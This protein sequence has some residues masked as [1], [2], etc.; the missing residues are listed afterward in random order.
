MHYYDEQLRDLQEQVSKKKKLEGTLKALYPQKEELDKKVA[1]L[2][3]IKLRE[4][5]DV[6]KLENGSLSVFFYNVIGKKEEK[7][8]KERQEAYAA[9]AKYNSAIRELEYVNDSIRSSEEELNRLKGSEAKYQ[10]LLMEKKESIKASG[11][12]GAREILDLEEQIAAVHNLKKELAEA[13]KEGRE[14][15][16]KVEEVLHALDDADSLG[17]WDAWGGDGIF[18]HMAKHDALDK[19][20]NAVEALQVELRSFKTELADVQMDEDLKVNLDDFTRFADW[21]FDNI[22]T[23]LD[24]LDQIHESQRKMKHIDDKIRAILKELSTKAL[25]ADL[26]IKELQE[27]LEKTIIQT[28]I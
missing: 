24:V 10:S 5:K 13:E 21:F 9:A 26:E 19:A 7:L 2:E 18:L 16:N 8:D 12:N 14:A 27:K 25:Y 3:A 6:D 28:S 23:D 17:T 1:E 20:Q 4:Q 22:F 11:A 15:R